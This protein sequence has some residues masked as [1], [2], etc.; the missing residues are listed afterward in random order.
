MKKLVRNGRG[1]SPVVSTVILTSTILAM[2]LS[3]SYLAND[4]LTNQMENAEFDVAKDVMDALNNMVKEVLYKPY[5]SRYVKTGF[6][7]TMPN[8]HNTAETINVWT[9]VDDE[10][11]EY[12]IQ[13]NPISIV[14]IKGGTSVTDL[15]MDVIG[16]SSVLLNDFTSL[17]HLFIQRSDQVELILDFSRIRCIYS[18]SLNVSQE[19][20]IIEAV[21]VNMTTGSIQLNDRA[22]I[23]VR[24]L[25]TTISQHLYQGTL[26]IGIND[27]RGYDD[28]ILYSDLPHE[29]TLINLMVIDIEISIVGGV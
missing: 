12:L 8:L 1:L 24:N 15:S 28:A 26:T 16:T 20:N 3:T 11:I 23:M 2:V 17:G 29:S 10:P 13:N 25:G 14:T 5:S 18:G 7:T 22:V 19:Y 4:L 9:K 21:F 6:R 27:T